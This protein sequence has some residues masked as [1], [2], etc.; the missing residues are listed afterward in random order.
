[1]SVFP[2]IPSRR[3][4]TSRTRRF[5]PIAGQ[6]LGY[7]FI[8]GSGAHQYNFCFIAYCV[9]DGLCITPAVGATG[10]ITCT[11]ATLANGATGTF[12]VTVK[13]NTNT[14]I[15]TLI[16]DGATVATTTGDPNSTTIIAS[17]TNCGWD[18]R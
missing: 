16:T 15:G 14:A 1:M 12:V 10:T 18:Q 8:H 7:G 11:I 4:T 5:G 9:R 17:L 3:A 13:V 2:R 6:A